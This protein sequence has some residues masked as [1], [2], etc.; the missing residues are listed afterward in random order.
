MYKVVI[1]LVSVFMFWSLDSFGQ[2]F[3]EYEQKMNSMYD[4]FRDNADKQYEDFYNRA[5]AQYADFIKQAW[6]EFKVEPQ[7]PEPKPNPPVQPVFNPKDKVVPQTKVPTINVPPHIT[8]PQAQPVKPIPTKIIPAQKISVDFFGAECTLRADKSALAMELEDDSENSVSKG[9]SMLSDGRTNALI[10]DCLDLREQLNLCDWAYYELLQ[11]V[12][13]NIYGD[14]SSREAIVLQAYIMTQSGYQVRFGRTK[15]GLML[16]MSTNATV[17]A[18]PYVFIDGA[19]FYALGSVAESI[20]VCNFKFP[21][22]S[23]LSL[24]MKSL[25]TLPVDTI[26]GREL[27]SPKMN[28]SK[29]MIKHNRNL[30][31]FLDSYPRCSIENF[32]NASLD[33]LAKQSLY[34][35]LRNLIADKTEE[36]AANI[37]IDF[38]QRA[39]QYKVDDEQFGEERTL[40]ANETLYYPYSDCEDR[41]LLYAT[42]VKDL[43]GLDVVLLDYPEHIAT[44]VKFNQDIDGDYMLINDEKYLICDPTYIG[45]TIG[46]CMPKYQEIG[47]QIIMAN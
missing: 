9:W 24:R 38:V 41:S 44:A 2:S 42:L 21:G 28:E 37:L 1:L 30:I 23:V 26:Q 5:N 14:K 36:V 39:F 25:P 10:N 3:E 27:H 20:Y 8:A 18:T 35:T 47:A 19:K 46:I 31:N 22:E 34:P 32:V 13:G 12:T 29:I 4:K 17:Y 7:I 6:V 33:S 11:Q 15:D 16:L 40:F 45:A 43:L